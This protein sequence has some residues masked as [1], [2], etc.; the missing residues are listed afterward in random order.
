M[1]FK[2]LHDFVLVKRDEAEEEKTPGGLFVPKSH[3]RVPD[4]AVVEAVG[5]G[6][7]LDDGTLLKPEVAVGDVIAISRHSGTDIGWGVGGS[8][9]R[10]VISCQDIL[11]IVERQPEDDVEESD[12][13][14]GKEE[15][16]EDVPDTQKED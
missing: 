13:D 15:T 4:T 5:P 16:Q 7:V 10:T 1:I 14:V 6:R 11:G 12:T 3:K 8:E 9:I 2:P